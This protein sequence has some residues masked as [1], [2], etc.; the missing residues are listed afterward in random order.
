MPSGGSWLNSGQ[1][2]V[3]GE[4]GDTRGYAVLFSWVCLPD[5][6]GKLG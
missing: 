6:K 4:S 3:K 5:A 2:Q 1:Q